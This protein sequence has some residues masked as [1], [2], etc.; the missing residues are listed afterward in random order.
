MFHAYDEVAL[1]PLDAASPSAVV[2]IVH[3][4]YAG[5]SFTQTDDGRMYATSDACDLFGTRCRRI[6]PATPAHRAALVRRAALTV[7]RDATEIPAAAAST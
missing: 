2:R 4:T 6:V 3:V 7:G 1:M 5:D